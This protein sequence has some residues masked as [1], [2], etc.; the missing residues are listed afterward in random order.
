MSIIYRVDIEDTTG[1]IVAI[2]KNFISLSYNIRIGGKGDFQQVISGFDPVNNL[3]DEDYIFRVWR[4]DTDVFNPLTN[5]VVW[6]NT[7]SGIYKTFTKSFT[8]SGNKTITYYGPD[9][10]ELLEKGY[11]LY[12]PFSS[13]ASKN[14]AASTAMIEFVRENIGDLATIANNRHVNHVNPIVIVGNSGLGPM[15]EDDASGA[16]LLTTLQDIREYTRQQNDQI[17]FLMEYDG[18]YRWLFSAGYLFNDRTNVGLNTSTGRNS[19][20]NVPVVFSPLYNNVKNFF[21]SR[22]RYNEVNTMVGVG[23]GVGTLQEFSVQQN[24]PSV[25]TSP[26]AQREGIINVNNSPN[27]DTETRARLKESIAETK[28]SFE[29]LLASLRVWRDFEPGDYVTAVDENNVNYHMQLVGLSVDVSQSEGGSTIE[30][31]NFDF[32]PA[33]GF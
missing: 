6:V 10:H 2:L 22:S 32:Q 4:A 8:Q 17:D 29:P 3:I 21:V 19:V 7:F 30:R 1:S 14:V 18:D 15:W 11:I 13:Q 20:G 33:I 12:A 9:S 28:V 16:N 31:L 25:L 26:I 27:L 23:N 24:L 5:K